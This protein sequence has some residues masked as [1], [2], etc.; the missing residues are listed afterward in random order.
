M[1]TKIVLCASNNSLTAGL[2]RAG[3]LQSYQ[4]FLNDEQGWEDFKRFLQKN[5]NTTIY[6]LVDAVEEDYRLETLPHTSGNA[7]YELVERKLN[8]IYRGINYR[9]AHYINREKDKRKDDRFLF[10]SLNNP[11]FIQ[12]WI[13][14]IEEQQAPLAGVYLL[15]M[16]S[17]AMIRKLKL[18]H[19][20]IVLSE[21][22]HSGL[23]QSY[24]HNGRLRISRLAPIPPG[25]ENRLGYFYI[26]ET[27]KTRLYLISQRFIT[28]DTALTI[29]LPALDES[30]QQICR[31][32]E[33]E[34]GMES[35]TIDLVQF[36]KSIHLD[37]QLLKS[38]PELLHM[39]LLANGHVPDNLAPSSLI[40]NHKLLYLQRLINSA[41]ALI[42]LVGL[43]VAGIY[44]YQTLDQVELAK[45]AALDTST[46]EHLYT[47]VAKDFP[48]TPIASNDL[49]TAVELNQ[50]IVNFYRSPRRM[51]QIL[52]LALDKSS[53]IQLDRLRWL[54]TND[55]NQRDE[56]KTSATPSPVQPGK[57]NPQQNIQSDTKVL[58]EIGFIN[59]EIKGFAGDYRSALASVNHFTELLKSDKNVE[60]VVILQ[61]PVNVSSYSNLQGTTADEQATQKLAAL[62]KLKVVLK[63]E[64]P[65]T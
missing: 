21:R 57:G 26:T 12:G 43:I 54:L 20:H 62:F 36:A 48:T 42:V 45:Q 55:V 31:G 10:A 15:P 13:V 17:Q 56:D 22:L 63:R 23:R 9:V 50:D 34:H 8:Q 1:F 41:T 27:D 7:R 19:P 2:W 28:R 30:A 47:E 39:H 35:I 11:D 16:V 18:M 60:Q 5:I 49:K 46:Q 3:R 40:K 25:T 52:S 64:V 53:E 24:L 59:A 29:V 14:C 37:Q 65:P 4:I 44:F 38:N 32:I 58:H 61:E 33:Q 6:M 51:M